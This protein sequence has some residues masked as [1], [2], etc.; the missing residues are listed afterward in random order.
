M[1]GLG[2]KPTQQQQMTLQRVDAL[3]P[4]EKQALKELY[5][6]SS[7]LYSR[8]FLPLTLVNRPRVIYHLQKVKEG[9]DKLTKVL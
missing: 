3:S 4:E 8:T 7:E 6:H 5:Y 9:V 1:L 2:K